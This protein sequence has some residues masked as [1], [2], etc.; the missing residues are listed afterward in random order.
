M[1]AVRWFVNYNIALYLDVTPLWPDGA[2]GLRTEPVGFPSAFWRV[3]FA[4]PGAGQ[5]FY[6]APLSRKG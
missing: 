5:P 6:P 1:R 3:R 4:H 2:E